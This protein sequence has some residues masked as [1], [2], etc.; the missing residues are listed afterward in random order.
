MGLFDDFNR[1]LEDRLEEFLRNN[2]HLELQALEEQLRE[3]EED[4]LRLI[5]D[6]KQQ[7]KNLQDEIL[8]I[9]QDIQR[10]HERVEKAQSHGRQDLAQAAQEREA[11]LLRQGNQ[12]WGQMEGVK[13]RIQQS[14]ELIRQIQTRRQEV[15]TKA[16]EVEAA[17]ASNQDQSKVETFGWNQSS[18]RQSYN[19]PDPLDDQFRRWEL[20]EELDQMKRNMGR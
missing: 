12:R 18:S 9:A 13:Q 1:F 8:A 14:Q 16:K 11:T 10:W 2:P 5:A 3:Q 20:Q 4:S 17:R 15:R 19:G 7:Q 6:L